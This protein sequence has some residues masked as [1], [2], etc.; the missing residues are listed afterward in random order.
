MFWKKKKVKSKP[1]FQFNIPIRCRDDETFHD[2]NSIT[3]TCQAPDGEV[4]WIDCGE[5][6]NSV[7]PTVN[8]FNDWD[9]LCS[10]CVAGFLKVEPTEKFINNLQSARYIPQKNEWEIIKYLDTVNCTETQHFIIVHNDR[11]YQFWLEPS[12]YRVLLSNCGW[13]WIQR[14][15]WHNPQSIVNPLNTL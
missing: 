1:K 7:Y 10:F 14:A 6:K 3:I 13:D 9:Q 15:I 8:S 11:Q 4:T 2:L 12:K 5:I